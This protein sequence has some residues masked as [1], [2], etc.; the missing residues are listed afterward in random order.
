MAKLKIHLAADQVVLALANTDSECKVPFQVTSHEG[1]FEVEP[2]AIWNSLTKCVKSLMRDLE[3]SASE[4]SMIYI[5]SELDVTVLWDNETLGAVCPARGDA[6][7]P[8]QRLVLLTEHNPSVEGTRAAGR[9]ASGSAIDYLITRMTRGLFSDASGA[10]IITEP[11][12]FLG[13]T[14]QITA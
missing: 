3:I 10:G 4:I 12:G 14:A 8:A 11:S 1:Y 2:Q 6:T 7:S 5:S 13:I 9:L